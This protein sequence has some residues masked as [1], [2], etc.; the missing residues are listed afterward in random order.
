VKHRYKK[1]MAALIVVCLIIAGG[2]V[3]VLIRSSH[4]PKTPAVTNS[5]NSSKPVTAGG[6]P[7]PSDS[8]IK[9]KAKGYYCPSWDAKPGQ[10][11]STICI[12]LDK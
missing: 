5:S 1:I 8:Q 3:I 4:Q 12:P 2:V 7:V 9:A 10:V 6:V 11:A